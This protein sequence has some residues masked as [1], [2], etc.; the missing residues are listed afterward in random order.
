VNPGGEL[1]H[2]PGASGNL[3]CYQHPE[4]K[5]DHFIAIRFRRLIVAAGAVYC[6]IWRKI[7]GLEAAVRPIITASQPVCVTMAQASSGVRMSPLPMTGILTA[8]FT[9]AIHPSERC[10]LYPARRAGVQGNPAQTAGFRKF[11]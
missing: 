9:A 7:H 11:G 10:P 3:F 6:A 8:C 4:C 1:L 5:C 2:L